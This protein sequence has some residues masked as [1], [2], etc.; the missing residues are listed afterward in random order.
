MSLGSLNLSSQY[1]SKRS[2]S[3]SSYSQCLAK[4]A[5]L[6]SRSLASRSCRSFSSGDTTSSPGFFPLSSFPGGAP[7]FLSIL[8][9]F[10]CSGGITLGC[11]RLRFLLLGQLSRQ[12]LPALQVEPEEAELIGVELL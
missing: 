11:L 10:S 5:A 6:S 3:V 2:C 12:Q 7:G 4:A 9:T 8:I 1:L